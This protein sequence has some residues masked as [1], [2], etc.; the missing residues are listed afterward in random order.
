MFSH[1]TLFERKNRREHVCGAQSGKGLRRRYVGYGYALTRLLFRARKTRY[2]QLHGVR[3]T[4][5]LIVGQFSK[6]TDARYSKISYSNLSALARGVEIRRVAVLESTPLKSVLRYLCQ[7]KYL[8][9]EVYDAQEKRIGELRQSE[10]AEIF[11]SSSLYAPIG[12]I[13]TK[14]TEKSEKNSKNR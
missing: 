5:F 12:D 14:H 2:V 1:A 8:L 3:F 10:F 4:F 9:L 7:G 13:F 11:K 6:N